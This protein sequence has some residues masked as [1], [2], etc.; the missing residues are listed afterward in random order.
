MGTACCKAD[1]SGNNVEPVSNAGRIV[2]HNPEVEPEPEGEE[3]AHHDLP[4][5]PTRATARASS[6]MLPFRCSCMDNDEGT[7]ETVDVQ[8]AE[9][10][11]T[12]EWKGEHWHGQGKV[13]VPGSYQ[14]EGSFLESQAHGQGIYR[15]AEG[16]TFEGQWYR[17]KKHGYGVFVHHDGAVFA[18]NWIDDEKSGA[19]V[20]SW[21][22][23]TRY[24]G[25]FFHGMR[26]GTGKYRST[27]GKYEGQFRNDKME[28]QGRYD[29]TSGRS[30]LGQW[31]DGVFLGHGVMDFPDGSKYDGNYERGVRCGVG[32]MSWP[33][34]RSYYGEWADG[35]QNGLGV[36]TNKDGTKIC[37]LWRDGHLAE[38]QELS[39]TE[40]RPA[41]S[42]TTRWTVILPV[43][44]RAYPSVEAES[45]GTKDK[46][47]I[48]KGFGA[49]DWLALSEENGF[50]AIRSN[51]TTLLKPATGTRTGE[52]G[53]A[54]RR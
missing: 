40:M 46:G 18:G 42:K 13:S 35:N 6:S 30:Y 50:V 22:D 15:G 37:G 52:L 9:P 17:D 33:D 38:E 51:G 7:A 1:G 24:K 14:Y 2:D 36:M 27:R 16:T 53:S 47:A 32:T 43:H 26:H 31:Q 21:V 10:V 49:G 12:G 39:V 25:E 8:K 11:Y 3:I 5:S 19:G 44:V 4:P 34:G 54:Q 28:G 23:G 48:I 20:E 45:L 41:E 29:F